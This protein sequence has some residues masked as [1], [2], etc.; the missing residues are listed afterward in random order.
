MKWLS[1][2]LFTIT[3]ML[4]PAT[5]VIERQDF[6]TWSNRLLIPS[7]EPEPNRHTPK[8][9]VGTFLPPRINKDTTLSIDDNPIILTSTTYIQPGVTLTLNP[10]TR[11][12]ANENANLSISGRLISKGNQNQPVWFSSNEEHPLNQ[13]WS[14]VS[15]MSEGTAVLEHTT[16]EDASP[17][18]SCLTKSKISVSSSKIT[19]TIM[20]AFITG[21][22]CS[23]S[24]TVIRSLRDGIVVVNTNP[25]LFNNIITAKKDVIKK[26]DTKYKTLNT[27]Y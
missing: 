20:G 19:K 11:L 15:V 23:I 9:F 6:S 17:A 2:T 8:H 7:F 12:Y 24:D 10:G 16:I 21:R 22:D 25:V 27:K 18:I 5:V 13:T 1:T 26:V 3:L 4:L 14:G